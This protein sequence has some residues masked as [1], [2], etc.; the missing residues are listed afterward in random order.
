MSAIQRAILAALAPSPPGRHFTAEQLFTVLRRQ[1]P[2][3]SLATI[4]RN[5]AQFS[6]EGR[7]RRVPRADGA[8][9][10][11]GNLSPHDHAHCVR[12]QKPI[13]LTIPHL[14]ELIARELDGDLISFDLAV[15]Y[16]CAGCKEGA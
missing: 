13:D 4:Y 14:K 1:F 11:E 15:T 8:D 5:L 16:L 6:G 2:R 9:Y 3:V 7:I 10:Y 12:C